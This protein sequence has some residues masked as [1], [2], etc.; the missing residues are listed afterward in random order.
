MKLDLNN[1]IKLASYAVGGITL[2][3]LVA[4]NPVQ[5]GF[6][7]ASAGAYFIADRIL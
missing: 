7:A 2:L 3:T 6:L 1:I 4:T 5:V